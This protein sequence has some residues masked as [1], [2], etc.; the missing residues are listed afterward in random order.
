VD[1]SIDST[2]TEGPGHTSYL[3]D[4][5]DGPALVVDPARIPTEQRRGHPDVAVLLGGSAAW[6]GPP[7]HRAQVAR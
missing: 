6:W 7:G 1:P 5:G 4:R 2:V 3:V